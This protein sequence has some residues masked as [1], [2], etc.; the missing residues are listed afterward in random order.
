MQPVAGMAENQ[1]MFFFTDMGEPDGEVDHINRV[2]LDNRMQNLRACTSRQ[3]SANRGLRSNN[4]SGCTGVYRSN[5]KWHARI[6]V[7][8]KRLNLGAFANK[9]DA[10][11][12]RTL[13]EFKYL[14][15]FAPSARDL[16][17]LPLNL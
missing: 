8:D 17:V 5:N 14:G 13:A 2:S 10:V 6:R 7:G 3:N 4:T 12:A 9:E 1:R 15:E 16:L 11:T